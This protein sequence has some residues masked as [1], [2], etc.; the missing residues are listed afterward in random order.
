MATSGSAFAEHVFALPQQARVEVKLNVRAA[1]SLSADRVRRFEPGAEIAVDRWVLGDSL[2]GIDRWFRIAERAEFIWSGGA[3]LLETATPPPS[4]S[5]GAPAVQRRADG[6]IRPLSVDQIGGVFGAFAFEAGTVHGAVR[7]TTPNWEADNLVALTHPLAVS[8]AG[9]HLR[10]H[11]LAVRHFNAAFDEITRR[12][13]QSALLTCGGTFVARKIGW[14]PNRVLSSHSWGIAIDLNERW[15]ALNCEPA[16]PGELG[17]L[18][19]L[20]PIFAAQGFAWGGDFTRPKD[21]MH[22]ELARTNP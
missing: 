17:C 11:R 3:S 16:L 22:F 18:R 20:V 14:D 6:S 8:L 10:V 5:A 15:N 21:G 1:P 2:L 13:L 4:S 12:N 19:E 9:S 7:I